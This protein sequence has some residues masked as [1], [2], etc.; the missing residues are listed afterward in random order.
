[1]AVEQENVAKSFFPITI[2]LETALALKNCFCTLNSHIAIF[3][4]QIVKL[5]SIKYSMQTNIECPH[6]ILHTIL[7]SLH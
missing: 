5:Y 6:Y 2:R 4:K 1:M 7:L 3:R